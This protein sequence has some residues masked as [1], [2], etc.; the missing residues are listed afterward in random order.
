MGI[1]AKYLNDLDQYW[2]DVWASRWRP[3]SRAEAIGGLAFFAWFLWYAMGKE[4]GD[5][6][7]LDSGNA[8]IHEGG[9]ALF[10]YFPRFMTVAGGTILQLLVPF[11]LALA[12]YVRRQALGTSLLMM[13]VFENFLGISRYMAD[14]RAMALQYIV[15]GAGVMSGDEM[16]PDMHDWHYMFSHLGVLNHDTSIAAW[17]FRLGWA[18]MLGTVLWFAYR[19][20]QD[21]REGRWGADRGEPMI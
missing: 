10:S 1:L 18:G 8:V 15:I 3:L 21:W 9:H 13:V 14:A 5:F 19:C 7:F 6:L 12:F 16:D 4:G 2:R 17:V 20:Y 11:L